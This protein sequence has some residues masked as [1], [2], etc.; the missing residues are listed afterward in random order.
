MKA[1][2]EPTAW[3]LYTNS[4]EHSDLKIEETYFLSIEII[5]H[6]KAIDIFIYLFQ[7]I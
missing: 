2:N 4:N 6:M 3:A 7:D 1:L 5:Q